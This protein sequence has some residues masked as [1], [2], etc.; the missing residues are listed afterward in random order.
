MGVCV[1]TFEPFA[2]IK[3]NREGG[4]DPIADPELRDVASPFMG[5]LESSFDTTWMSKALQSRI[6]TAIAVWNGRKSALAKVIDSR[7]YLS[8]TLPQELT[9]EAVR[10]ITRHRVTTVQSR[11]SIDQRGNAIVND[12]KLRVFLCH[13]SPDKERVRQLFKWLERDGF[14]PWLDEENLFAGQDWDYEIRR[15]VRAS[16]IVIVCLSS[17]AITKQGYIQKEIRVALDAADEKPEGMI[18]LIPLR[19]ED[20]HVPERLK[21]WHWVDLFDDRG[22]ERLLAA[23]RRSRQNLVNPLLRRSRPIR[24]SAASQ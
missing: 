24:N 3:P 12:A 4:E 13:A 6:R 10:A 22:Y 14:E 2:Y 15:T 11:S 19:L 8:E 17:S 1:G 5:G 9:D 20:C 7:W 16:D 18:F 21:R 23:L